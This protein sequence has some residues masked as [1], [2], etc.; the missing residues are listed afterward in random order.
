MK[1]TERTVTEKAER[2]GFRLARSQYGGYAIV[3][4]NDRIVAPAGTWQSMSLAEADAWLSAYITGGGNV[5]P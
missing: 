2:L 1:M 3:D 5:T 4:Q